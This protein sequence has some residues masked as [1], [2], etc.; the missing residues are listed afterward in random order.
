[1]PDHAYCHIPF[2]IKKCK[3]CTF[4]SFCN[5]DLI[6]KYID[7]LCLEIS[8]NYNQEKLKTLYFGGG[9]PSLLQAWQFEKLISKFNI[10]KETE[11][12]VELNPVGLSFEYMN[13]LKSLNVNRLSFGV[14]SFDDVILKKIGRD[15]VSKDVFRSFEFAQKAGFENINFDFIYGLMEDTSSKFVKNLETAYSLGVS[16]VSLYGLHIERGSFFYKHPP[17]SLPDMDIQADIYESSVEFLR[18]K[19]FVHYEISNFSKKGFESRHNLN[20]WEHGFYYGFG[21][22]SCGFEENIRYRNLANFKKYFEKEDKKEEKR[23]LSTQELLEEEIFLS[24]RTR[25]GICVDRINKMFGIDFE[26]RY[27]K[28]LEKFSGEF[29]E[30]FRGN[31]R[32]TLRGIL[33]SNNILS[34][35]L[36]Y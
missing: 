12:T 8:K 21:L 22:G 36:G 10:D 1:M 16:H 6:E 7:A 32:L 26:N 31:W 17:Q 30:N 18:Q 15:H 14:Q 34:E 33:V 9:T 2:C 4:L 20:C 29:L 13:D 11:I 3:N 5:L 24:L 19:G 27:K 23:S 25:Q 28:V 35:F